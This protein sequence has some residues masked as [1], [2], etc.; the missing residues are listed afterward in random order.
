MF[1]VKGQ[2]INIFG[3]V[4]HTVSVLLNSC[5]ISMK[6]DTDR[7]Y[8]NGHS[9]VPTTKHIV[10]RFGPW[11]TVCQVLLWVSSF[12]YIEGPFV[13]LFLWTVHIFCPFSLLVVGLFFLMLFLGV[14]YILALCL[15]GLFK[16]FFMILANAKN[17]NFVYSDFFQCRYAG[18]SLIFF[19]I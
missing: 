16:I 18:G 12:S 4:S 8:M 14:L 3:F 9:C 2:I 5:A 13:F 15:C 1:S 6:E 19:F 10:V 7:M 11:A 17:F